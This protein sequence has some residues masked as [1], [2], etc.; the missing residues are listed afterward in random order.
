MPTIF[1]LLSNMKKQ[2]LILFSVIALAFF[3]FFGKNVYS[4]KDGNTCVKCHTDEQ[5]IR[6]L[7][8]PPKIEFR[9]E[10]GEG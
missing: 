3:A 9:E 1:R 7:Y 2:P 6:S 5:K 8:M 4:L 10:E